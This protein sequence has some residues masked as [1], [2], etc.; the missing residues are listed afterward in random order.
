M[1]R[2]KGPVTADHARITHKSRTYLGL[3]VLVR[4]E[5]D[6]IFG[7][8]GVQITDE[9]RMNHAWTA[10]V[11]FTITDESLK[12]C[13]RRRIQANT[14]QYST[15]IRRTPDAWITDWTRPNTLAS[16]TFHVQASVPRWTWN[17][18]SSCDMKVGRQWTDVDVRGL[19]PIPTHKHWRPTRVPRMVTHT[20][21]INYAR[22]LMDNAHR[23]IGVRRNFFNRSKL[24]ITHKPHSTHIHL[25]SLTIHRRISHTTHAPRRN[26]NMC[27]M[28]ARF[29]RFRC[30]T[31]P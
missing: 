4:R 9:S 1:Y 15:N 23:R 11:P 8:S 20:R 31:G 3:C 22:R 30:V 12:Y 14:V 26:K 10:H 27:V 24:K 16:P 6:Q 21:R 18:R 28:R 19:E 29:M 5:I 13:A 25:Q 2:C 17:V 7:V